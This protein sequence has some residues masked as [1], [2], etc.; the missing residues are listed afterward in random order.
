M[1]LKTSVVPSYVMN[2][3]VLEEVEEIKDLGVHYVFHLS[4]RPN[5]KIHHLLSLFVFGLLGNF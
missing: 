5:T 2:D 4:P 1:Y 3:T